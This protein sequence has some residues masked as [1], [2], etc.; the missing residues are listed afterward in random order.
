MVTELLP[1]AKVEVTQTMVL[2]SCEDLNPE[3]RPAVR[4]HTVALQHAGSAGSVCEVEAG[5]EKADWGTFITNLKKD[6]CV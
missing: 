2:S 5:A 1:L 3:C 6:L 4:N